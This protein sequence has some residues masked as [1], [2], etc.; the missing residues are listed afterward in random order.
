M[1]EVLQTMTPAEL[2]KRLRAAGFFVGALDHVT[3]VTGAASFLCISEK[4]LE[5]WREEGRGPTCHR[6]ARW[7][8]G[9]PELLQFWESRKN[10]TGSN[11][12]KS[13][14]ASPAQHAENQR[15]IR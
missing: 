15:N 10:E 4:T 8:Y 12:E 2:A 11:R 1:R 7:L 14:I 13:A 3:D 6:G 9:L 5:N